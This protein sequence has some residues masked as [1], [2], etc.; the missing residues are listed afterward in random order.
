LTSSVI[1]Y[2]NSSVLE[3]DCGPIALGR[4]LFQPQHGS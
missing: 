4:L 2:P 1:R 3:L